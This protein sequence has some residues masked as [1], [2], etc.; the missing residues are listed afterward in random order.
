MRFD[1]RAA[2]RSTPPVAPN[3]VHWD[4]ID[5]DHHIRSPRSRVGETR[6]RGRLA[7]VREVFDVLWTD[8][9]DALER[10]AESRQP[11]RRG[12]TA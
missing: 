1:Q 10:R 4:S 8:Q 7:Q 2:G 11:K 6:A 3:N 9:L 12:K 5:M